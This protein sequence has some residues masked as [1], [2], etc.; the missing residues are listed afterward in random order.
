MKSFMRTAYWTIAIF[1]GALLI[2]YGAVNGVYPFVANEFFSA[3]YSKDAA[4]A[5]MGLFVLGILIFAGPF[6]GVGEE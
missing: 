1:G 2:L 6:L 5:P 4:L 3:T